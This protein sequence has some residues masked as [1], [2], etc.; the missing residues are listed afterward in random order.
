MTKF[1]RQLTHPSRN[2]ETE[3]GDLLADILRDSL[4][5]EIFLLGSGSIRSTEMGPIVLYSDFVEC[6][7]YDDAAYL[8]QVTGEQLKRMIRYM[9]RDEVWK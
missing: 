8:M 4:G 9:L 1:K 2:Q 6:F 7:A 3:L 5:I